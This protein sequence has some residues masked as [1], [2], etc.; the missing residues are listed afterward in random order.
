MRSTVAKACPVR[1]AGTS[2]VEMSASLVLMSS[3]TKLDILLICGLIVMLR[4]T[5]SLLI[6]LLVPVVVV[7]WVGAGAGGVDAGD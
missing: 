3:L 4:E 2:R 5:F 1:A 7:V 6:V